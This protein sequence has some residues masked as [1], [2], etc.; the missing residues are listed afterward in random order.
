[1]V[2]SQLQTV[3]FTCPSPAVPPPE[4]AVS[5]SIAANAAERSLT[6]RESRMGLSSRPELIYENVSQLIRCCEDSRCRARPVSTVGQREE[7]RHPARGRFRKNFVEFATEARMRRR[8]R[9]ER[10]TLADVANWRASLPPPP[11]KSSTGAATWA[12]RRAA[13]S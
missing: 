4:Q 12:R 3:I 13:A 7:L 9:S 8:G 6:F 2:P 11:P 1:T 5:A 10:A